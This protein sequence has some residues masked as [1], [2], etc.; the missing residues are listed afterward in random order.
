[1]IS[2]SRS[3]IRRSATVCTRPADKPATNL[4]PQQRRN[5]VSDQAVQ[6]P[7]RLLRVDQVVIDI[8]GVFEC[9]LHRFLGDFVEGHAADA[10]FFRPRPSFFFFFFFAV[11]AQFIGQMR[12]DS[13]AFAVRVRREIDVVRRSASFFSWRELSLCQE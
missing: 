8:A 2:R 12:S 7:A 5:L 10:M 4:V 9:F 6:N 3:T 1:M 13:F 11:F